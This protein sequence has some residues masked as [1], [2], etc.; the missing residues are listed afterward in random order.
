MQTSDPFDEIKRIKEDYEKG[1]DIT[2]KGATTRL[3]SL[4]YNPTTQR[5]YICNG[6]IG[7]KPKW[8]EITSENARKFFLGEE[9][10]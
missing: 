3:G 6:Q 10:T 5:T 8:T 9:T 7:G 2:P 1:G 4:W